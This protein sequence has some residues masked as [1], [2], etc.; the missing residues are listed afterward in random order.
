MPELDDARVVVGAAGPSGDITGSATL[1]DH[2]TRIAAREALTIPTATTDLSDVSGTPSVGDRWEWD[3]AAWV[4][5]TPETT[6]PFSLNY[7]IDG[8][9]AVLTTGVKGH[10][11]V[12]YTS[13]ITSAGLF[14]EESGNLEVDIWVANYVGALPVG[15]DTITGGNELT[16]SA[17]AATLDTTLTGWDTAVTAGSLIRFNIDS[18]ATITRVTIVLNFERTI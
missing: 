17:S 10:V 14:A 8:G 5:V 9:G 16:L 11:Y 3:G 12:P 7:V 1:T 18:V 13:T 2:E 6:F 15:S 4:P